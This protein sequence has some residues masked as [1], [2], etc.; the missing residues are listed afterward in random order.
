ME[1]Q[2]ALLAKRVY[3]TGGY[4]MRMI[5]VVD[6]RYAEPATD[7]LALDD[8]VDRNLGQVADVVAVEVLST[9]RL[10][11]QKR[12]LLERQAW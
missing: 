1:R 5:C 6:F 2:Q 8:H 3:L 11:D 12:Q 4:S 10:L 9:L 7:P